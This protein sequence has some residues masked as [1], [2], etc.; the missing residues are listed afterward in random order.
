METLTAER[1]PVRLIA[2]LVRRDW[3][4]ALTVILHSPHYTKRVHPM[5]S[6]PLNVAIGGGAPTEVVT[7]LLEAYPDAT[8][9]RNH[10][11]YVPCHL[12]CYAGISSKG[13]K[14]LLQCNPDAMSQCTHM[15]IVCG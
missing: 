11:S 13:M 14:V 4:T 5:E 6:S 9:I 15:A 1:H 12:A 10:N 2:P 7:A 3:K 8:T